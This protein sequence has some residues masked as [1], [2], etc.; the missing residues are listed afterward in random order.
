MMSVNVRSIARVC[1][2]SLTLLVL[3]GGM[4]E[5]QSR[6]NWDNQGTIMAQQ[7]GWSQR[8]QN[9]Q[10]MQQL[11]LSEQQQQDIEAIRD[12]YKPQLE[13][14][15][16]AMQQAREQLRSLMTG[17]AN[18]SQIRSQYQQVQQLAQ[19]MGSLRFESMMEIRAVLDES[20]R[21]QFA[22]M[23]NQKRDRF[24]PGRGNRRGNQ[25]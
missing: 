2:V 17:N 3:G 14:G 19:Q 8:G 20:Q 5:A 22:E 23:M 21:Q 18:E 10:L 9:S 25:E 13:Q 15:R 12:R 6:R 4:A 7:G 24:G 16:E 11:N 1:S